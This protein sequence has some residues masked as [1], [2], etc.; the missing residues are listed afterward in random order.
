L[1]LAKYFVVGLL[2]GKSEIALI[3]MLLLLHLLLL[4][5]TVLLM[6][7]LAPVLQGETL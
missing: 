1:A 7:L 6:L 2:K 5:M 4:L 3:V